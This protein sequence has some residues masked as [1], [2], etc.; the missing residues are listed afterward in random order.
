VY[1]FDGSLIKDAEGRG[2]AFDGNDKQTEVRNANNEVVGQYYYDASGVMVKKVVPS[3]GETI[4]F[5][6]DH[7]RPKYYFG[8]SSRN[9]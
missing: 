9:A 5:V 4:V 1:V 8:N 7:G 3:T 2:F 6:Y